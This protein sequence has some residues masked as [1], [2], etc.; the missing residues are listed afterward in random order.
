M[1]QRVVRSTRGLMK[2]VYL[3]MVKSPPAK[4]PMVLFEL[5]MVSLHLHRDRYE[6]SLSPPTAPISVRFQRRRQMQ[7]CPLDLRK[8][9]VE[10]GLHPDLETIEMHPY[11]LPQKLRQL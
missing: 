2:I 4:R 8:L 11:N 6:A 9:G 3:G 1:N 5:I 10:V 7:Q